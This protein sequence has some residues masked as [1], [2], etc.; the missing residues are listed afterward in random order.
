MLQPAPP[1]IGHGRN[2]DTCRCGLFCELAG[3][4]AAVKGEQN[5][6]SCPLAAYRCFSPEIPL[7][8]TQKQI[9]FPL[10]DQTHSPQMLRKVPPLHEIMQRYLIQPGSGMLQVQL[11]FQAVVVRHKRLGQHHIMNTQRRGQR[12]GETAHID[13]RTVFQ[14]SL[15]RGNRPSM[16]AELTVIIILYNIAAVSPCPLQQRHPLRYWH[17]HPPGELVGR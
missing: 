11:A 4:A 14:E 9:M 6:E 7:D 10:V 13:H 8:G 5:V 17:H 2:T 15:Q 16:I 12:L 3:T 1:C